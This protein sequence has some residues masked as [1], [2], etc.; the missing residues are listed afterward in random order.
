MNTS[1]ISTSK[2]V[3]SNPY[4]MYNDLCLEIYRLLDLDG[5]Q[6]SIYLEEDKKTK[7]AIKSQISKL[8]FGLWEVD[9]LYQIKEII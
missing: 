8:S 6:L 4:A 5:K 7:N 3:V 2:Y 1:A 9:F